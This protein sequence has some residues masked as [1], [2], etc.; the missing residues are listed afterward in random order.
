MEATDTTLYHEVWERYWSS[1]PPAPHT[2]FWD[3]TP[4]NAAGLDLPRFERAFGRERP[5]IDF[6]CGNGTQ[7]R[8]LARKFP[9]VIGVDVSEAA[10]EAARATT[11]G[12]APRYEVLDGTRDDAVA[13]LAKRLG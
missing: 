4:E 11:L 3:T 2:A 9:N 6:G 7:T 13:A 12:D 10:I 8:F 1:L 5:L